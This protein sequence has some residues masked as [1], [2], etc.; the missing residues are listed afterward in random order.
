[1][2]EAPNNDDVEDVQSA[3]PLRRPKRQIVLLARY[4]D[5]NFVS[6]YSCFLASPN[7]DREP[8]CFDEVKD[9]I[10]WVDAMDDEMQALIKNQTWDLVPKPKNVKPITCKWVYK[11]RR[12]LDGS[13]D[14]YKARLVAQGFLQKYGEEYEETFSPVAK[15]TSVRVVISLAACCG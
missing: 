4:R 3:P 5:R 14:S 2:H 13:V 7:A 1:M 11:L 9:A 8:S 6:V 10:E 15:K 12:K